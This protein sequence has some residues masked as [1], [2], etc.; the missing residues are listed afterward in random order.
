MDKQEK[1]WSLVARKLSG[2]IS[3][4]EERELEE[5]LRDNPESKYA[6]GKLEDWWHTDEENK[7]TKKDSLAED[8]FKHIEDSFLKTSAEEKKAFSEDKDLPHLAVSQRFSFLKWAAVLIFM[9]AIGGG[10]Y[11]FSRKD[12]RYANIASLTDKGSHQSEI[13]TQYGSKS[14]VMLPDG[15]MVWLNSGSKL[16]YNN[17]TFGKEDRKVNLIGEGFFDVAKDA[18]VPFIIHANRVRVTVLGTRFDMKSY[19]NDQTIEATL[20]SGSIKI[21]FADS[22]SKGLIL[23]PHQKVTISKKDWRV[24]THLKALKKD[25]DHEGKKN[26]YNLSSVT[27]IPKDSTMVET[28]WVQN[29]LAFRSESFANLATQLERWY[30]VKIN[31]GN[32]KVKHYQFTGVF[33]DESLEQVLKALQITAPFHYRIEKDKQV[34]ITE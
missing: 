8:S 1:I 3:D 24:A 2:E 5:L 29:K 15:T 11:L 22:M 17:K 30:D 6:F 28:S 7:Q 9:I 10:I 25:E 19:P 26:R 34:Y 32:S 18:N 13:S 20:V 4:N 27:Y 14:R 21:G 16:T 33:M 31:F 23:K 12:N